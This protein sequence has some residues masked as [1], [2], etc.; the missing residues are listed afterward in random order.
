MFLTSQY[1]GYYNS[2][3]N[4]FIQSNGNFLF[5]ADNNNLV[6]F[7][8]T[9]DGGDGQSTTNFVLKAENAILSGSSV[10]IITERFFLGSDTQFVS[11]S[12]CNIEISSSKFHIQRDGDVVMN[13]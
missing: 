10:S 4:A 5:K 6:S 8:T 1:L 9:V 7:G 13:R 11:G 2:G 12:N 3:W